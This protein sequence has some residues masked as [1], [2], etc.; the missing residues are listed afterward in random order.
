MMDKDYFLKGKIETFRKMNISY[1]LYYDDVLDEKSCKYL[2]KKIK[3]YEKN[4]MTAEGFRWNAEEEDIKKTVDISL[5]NSSDVSLLPGSVY[6]E[7][8]KGFVNIEK[9]KKLKKIVDNIVK[10]INENVYYYLLNIGYFGFEFIGIN[11][12]SVDHYIKDKSILPEVD[13]TLTINSLTLRRYNS[14]KDGGYHIPHF[15]AMPSYSSYLHE[16]SK[17]VVTVTFYLNDIDHGGE[18]EFPLLNKVFRPKRGR[19]LMFPPYYTH[20]HYG[21]RAP[22]DKYIITSHIGE[23]NLTRKENKDG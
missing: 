4:G 11:K 18:T 22:K 10:I 15:D 12:Y 19:M 16:K 21:R 2:I 14:K 13:G 23:K 9:D 6:P 20:L 17:R 5:K 1:E 3:Y 7:G 8:E